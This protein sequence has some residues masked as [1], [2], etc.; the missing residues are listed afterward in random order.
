[1]QLHNHL[2]PTKEQTKPIKV[3]EDDI[4]FWYIVSIDDIIISTLKNKFK[5]F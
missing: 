5:L 1:L 2:N 4:F 3:E